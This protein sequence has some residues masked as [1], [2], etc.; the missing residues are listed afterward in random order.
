MARYELDLTQAE[1][2]LKR[3][4]ELSKLLKKSLREISQEFKELGK[5]NVDASGKLIGYSDALEKRGIKS[6]KEFRREQFQQNFVI[7]EGTQAVTNM[8]FALG[9]LSQGQQGAKSSTKE[10][11]DALLA[12]VAA[13]NAMEFS[14]FSLGQAGSKL[15]GSIGRAATSLSQ[16]GGIIGIVVGASAA[17][18]ALFDQSKEKA[19]AAARATERLRTATDNFVKGI[20]KEEAQKEL[21]VFTQ[22]L[23]NEE[24]VLKRLE[25]PTDLYNTRQSRTTHGTKE[26][27]EQSKKNVEAY[28]AVVD[29]LKAYID[30]LKQVEA[31]QKREKGARIEFIRNLYAEFE[32][33]KLV[34]KTWQDVLAVRSQAATK[35]S[36]IKVEQ[37]DEVRVRSIQEIINEMNENQL[38]LQRQMA[39]N[40]ALLHQGFAMLGV[41]ADS[42][43]GKILMFI[44][45]AMQMAQVLTTLQQGTAGPLGFLGPIGVGLG[46][47][48]VLFGRQSGGWTGP[49]PADRPVGLVHADEVVFE[50]RITERNRNDLLA[51]RTAMQR[52][53]SVRQAASALPGPT[54]MSTRSLERKMDV[55][56]SELRAWPARLSFNPR[57]IA[58]VVDRDRRRDEGREFG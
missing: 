23:A 40:F 45:M 17:L 3:T 35:A 50:K 56:I 4:D 14:M 52:G 55:M 31:V 54:A 29:Q 53:L 48:G 32:A 51:L 18:F 57:G 43:L 58:R 47:L 11:T 1:Q 44:Q 13:Q 39:S 22:M 33:G 34:V 12:G 49:G 8:V 19:E 28:R 37:V 7:R 9:F 46:M 2:A 21:D 36:P 42:T 27:I 20:G 24:A 25:G 38:T 26:Q 10:V 6:L 41:Q 16:Y 5:T 15:G 30:A